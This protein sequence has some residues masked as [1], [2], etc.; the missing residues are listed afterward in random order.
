MNIT[1]LL[2][3]NELLEAENIR[4]ANR[5]RE[6]ETQVVLARTELNSPEAAMCGR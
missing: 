4:L 6:L 2:A 5:V 1:D 3:E